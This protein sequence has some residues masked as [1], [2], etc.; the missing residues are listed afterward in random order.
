MASIILRLL[1]ATV[2]FAAVLRVKGHLRGL[3]GWNEGSVRWVVIVLVLPMAL[4]YMGGHAYRLADRANIERGRA[5]YAAVYGD[6]RRVIEATD[7]GA[8][9]W[10]LDCTGRDAL[11]FAGFRRNATDAKV[12]RASFA[13][14]TN[15]IIPGVGSPDALDRLFRDRLSVPLGGERGQLHPVGRD[16]Q[17]TV[18]RSTNDVAWAALNLQG[19]DGVVLAQD[20]RTGGIVVLAG[21]GNPSDA[22]RGVQRYAA[23]GS[24]FKLAL[25]AAWYDSGLGERT[26][27]CPATIR[28]GG[29][30][31]RNAGGVA[32]GRIRVPSEMLVHSCNT[33]AVGMAHVLRNRPGHSVAGAFERFGFAVYDSAAPTSRDTSFWATASAGWRVQMAPPPARLRITATP[34]TSKEE[35][36]QIAIG[37]GSVDATPIHVLRLVQAIG[38]DGV[39]L[40]PTVEADIAARPVQVRRVMHAETA[41]KLRSAMRTVVARG[42]ARSISGRLHDVGWS[43]GGKTGTA[44]VE[45]RADDGWF[46]G[47]LFDRAGRARFAVV[48]YLPGGG[49]GG[50]APA[51]VAARVGRAIA[52]MTNARGAE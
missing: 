48:V 25:A 27:G 49:P 5:Q 3:R 10:L 13:Q 31:I 12:M 15:R 8:W 30:T 22:A 52:V 45:G 23:P 47:L 32:R 6:D 24:V 34:P 19:R 33:A 28:A 26:L 4:T 36:A 9:G 38:N 51:E 21:R 1:L 2:G 7:A 35:W 20:V 42:T 18:C 50:G 39:M 16:V 43:I 37:Q 17:L 41:R 11:A 29:A 40:R 14:G 44:Q 46:A